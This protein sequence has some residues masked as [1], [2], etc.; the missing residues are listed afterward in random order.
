MHPV[1][2]GAVAQKSTP[3]VRPADF[4]AS[5]R[6]ARSLGPSRFRTPRHHELEQGSAA[7][8]TAASNPSRLCTPRR[9][10]HAH[11]FAS[12]IRRGLLIA[13][14]LA[15]LA[16]LLLGST[17]ASAAEL[18]GLLHEFGSFTHPTGVAIDQTS[19]DVFV[20]DGGGA[21]AVDVFGPEGAGPL[22]VLTGTGSEHGA[23]GESFDFEGRPASVAVDNDPASPSYRDVYVADALHNVV[24]KFRLKA[25]GE[26][27]YVCQ[28][29][30]WSGDGEEACL[31]SGGS[32]IQ[33]FSL[34]RGVTVDSNGNVYISSFEP[35][36][37]FV[38]EFGSTGQGVMLLNASEHSGLDGHP[39]GLAV[40]S[41]GDLLVQNT[42]EGSDVVRFIFS[43]PGVVESESTIVSSATA[44]AL[45]GATDH[46]YV[47]EGGE[48]VLV[49]GED[50]QREWK[51][52]ESF[53]LEPLGGGANS[54]GLTVDE[55][56]GDVYVSSIDRGDVATFGLVEVPDVTA[57][58]AT[59]L[60]P[61]TVKLSGAVD[62]LG[63]SGAEYRFEYGLNT[64]YG[65]ESPL[66]GIAGEGPMPV[67]FEATGLTP[68]TTYHCRVDATNTA[69]LNASSLFNHGP[70]GTFTTPP[71]LPEALGAEAVDVTSG[72][73]LFRGLV[74]P[75]NGS[76]TFHFEY[77]T[78]S[79]FGTDLPDITV[80]PEGLEPAAVE[81]A[82]EAPLQPGV[83]YHFALAARNA[84][85]ET[86]SSDGTFTVPSA[87]VPLP[88]GAPEGPEAPAPSPGSLVLLSPPGTPA[89]LS[90]PADLFPLQSGPGGPNPP[91]AAQRLASALKACNRVP[92][93][94]RAGCRRRARR[95][96]GPKTHGSAS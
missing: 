36:T 6:C 39:G 48:S 38:A 85:G 68:G 60:T 78:T 44:I 75:G 12:R 42:A 37:G 32:P 89:L 57:C 58:G 29:S 30:G 22:A 19:G 72:R 71:L 76:T 18:P 84:T 91:T 70:D 87:A 74:N 10:S 90:V 61:T 95:R 27:E 50:P 53:A 25:P 3:A 54:K 64:Q 56:T 67:A 41:N 11:P 94:R 15:L 88:P 9:H 31:P 8:L 40:D 49:L 55:G 51:R 96:Y 26:Y 46:L 93:R 7:L 43:S 47:D 63:T 33:P 83:L 59:E 66:T 2:Q 62:P 13:P 4:V 45:D 5:A 20:A 28:I 77:G 92:R 80:G 35:G 34:T 82:A 81:Q 24:D 52:L 23:P 69:G 1:A 16:S 73:V 17:P 86:V 65:F 21:E 79:A 14:L